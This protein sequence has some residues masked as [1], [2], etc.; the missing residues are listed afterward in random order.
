MA[1]FGPVAPIHVVERLNPYAAGDY[2]LLLAHD[3]AEHTRD[4]ANYFG[5]FRNFTI[6]MDNSVIELGGAVDLSVVK[7][8]CL[9]VDCTTIVLPDILLDGKATVESCS[10]ALETWPDA[11][12]DIIG[13]DRR[14]KGFMYVPQGKTIQE[15]AASAE[16]LAN[17]PDINFWGI[18]RNLVGVGVDRRDAISIAYALNP[19]RRIHLLGFS[20]DVVSDVLAAKDRRV[21]GIDSAV[22]LRA[23]SLGVQM[24]MA[25]DLPPRGNW[26][27]TATHVPMMDSNIELYKKWITR[28]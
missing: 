21:E 20:D 27:D 25:L 5:K 22:P 1:K 15:W 14:T 11:F 6:I 3:V 2:H 19:H 28:Y 13:T 17:H 16:R 24:S 7:K 4:Y 18:P 8:A 26:W 23:A 10:A 12:R 9:S